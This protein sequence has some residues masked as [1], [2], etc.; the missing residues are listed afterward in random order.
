MGTEM[1]VRGFC[2]PQAPVVVAAAV[3]LLLAVGAV[4]ALVTDPAGR[5]RSVA[6]PA[7]TVG[8]QPASAPG[9]REVA[10]PVGMAQ[11]AIPVAP[12][13]RRGGCVTVRYSAPGAVEL[14]GDL[15]RPEQASTHGVTVLLIHGGGGSIGDRN[16]S[17]AWDRWY[18][19][20]GF[21][22]FAMEYERFLPD[23]AGPIY[24]RQE[25][26]VKAAIQWLRRHR[27][28]ME[29]DAERIVAHGISHGSS[30]AATAL[31]TPDAPTFAGPWT[32]PDGSD[33]L[34]GLIGFYG[35][36]DGYTFSPAAYYGRS[37]TLY[38][39]ASVIPEAGAASGPVLLVV[40]TDDLVVSPDQTAIFRDA[41]VAAGRTVQT[42]VLP[43][44]GHGF[45][46]PGDEQLS[47]EGL[48]VAR[49]IA[50][51]FDEHFG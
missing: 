48:E 39:E 51:W 45:D 30:L 7:P 1:S 4:A 6:A 42:V 33:R 47:P 41:L 49:T 38:D 18:A 34:D 25:S 44:L 24:P 9:E 14:L 35:Y 26:Q 19:E 10:T 43:G 36:Y 31:V 40:G 20:A 11:T 15:C 3:G 13:G 21:A 32:W 17:E 37:Q 8:T 2:R 23:E 50:G 16:S 29:G 46:R 22:T 5:P 28:A 27:A 12:V